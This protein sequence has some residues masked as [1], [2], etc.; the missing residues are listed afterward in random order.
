MRGEH[1]QRDSVTPNPLTREHGLHAFVFLSFIFAEALKLVIETWVNLDL[2]AWWRPEVLLLL[3]VTIL[4]MQF[5]WTVFESAWFYGNSLLRFSCGV[6]EAGMFYAIAYLLRNFHDPS[7]RYF[8]DL[9]KVF[10]LFLVM[11]LLFNS[12]DLKKYFAT[13]KTERSRPKLLRRQI[14]RFEGIAICVV[15]IFQ[16]ASPW[17]AAALLLAVVLIYTAGQVMHY[18]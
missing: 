7:F 13:T 1:H 5:W 10:L 18:L 17:A 11:A 14:L 15:G 6:V 4:T 8:E 12:V 16:W 2:K 3:A 9:P